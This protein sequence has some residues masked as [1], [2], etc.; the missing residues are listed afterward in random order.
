MQSYTVYLFLETVK[1]CILFD[2]YQ[3]TLTM[4]GP[5]NIKLRQNMG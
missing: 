4:H 2:I 3:N 5:M 1:R